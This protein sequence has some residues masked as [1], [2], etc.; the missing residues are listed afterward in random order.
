MNFYRRFIPGAVNDQAIPNE[1][2][3]GPKIKKKTSIVWT[4]EL[5]QAFNNCKDSLSRPTSLAHPNSTAVVAITT[6]GSNT[7]IGAIIQQRIDGHWQPL[8][9]LSK[10][11][12]TSQ[13]KYSPYDRELL[14]IYITVKHY[15]HLLE[16][17]TFI[18]YEHKPLTY[19]FNQDP[20]CSSP[21]QARHPEFIC[22]VLH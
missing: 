12:S 17:R 21:R 2:L 5:E 13:K 14:A 16:G 6:D 11:L 15:R 10:K 4:E 1:V 7:A 3:K 9:S 22:S 18:I 8:A 20:L 19:T